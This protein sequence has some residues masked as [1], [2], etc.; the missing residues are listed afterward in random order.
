MT[1]K[2][3]AKQILDEVKIPREAMD[4]VPLSAIMGYAMAR[5][6]DEGLALEAA[7]IM[8]P[9]RSTRPPASD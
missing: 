1:T 3:T 8:S 5:M 9:A 6:I 2:K 7:Q 4:A